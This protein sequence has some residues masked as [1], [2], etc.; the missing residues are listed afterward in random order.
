[1]E[2]KVHEI[3]KYYTL[4]W[5]KWQSWFLDF[6]SICIKIYLMLHGFLKAN[7]SFFAFPDSSS[8]SKKESWRRPFWLIFVFFYHPCL[9]IETCLILPASPVLSWQ[10]SQLQAFKCWLVLISLVGGPIGRAQTCLEKDD[11]CE[12]LKKPK[13][14]WIKQ[15]K[16]TRNQCKIPQIRKKN[17][18]TRYTIH[19][20]PNSRRQ[21][22]PTPKLN[23][24]KQRY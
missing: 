6:Y 11:I 20:T 16:M 10:W 7:V 2:S 24:W 9:G 12:T 15:Q 5:I 18:I 3:M 17:Y 14:P 1:M 13:R 4:V 22:K 21:T 23:I 8:W 19:Y